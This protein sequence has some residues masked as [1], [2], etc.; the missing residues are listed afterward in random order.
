MS[1]DEWNAELNSRLNSQGHT[2]K[3]SDLQV[4]WEGYYLDGFTPQQAIDAAF[5]DDLNEYI[6]E[7]YD[8][9]S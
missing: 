5:E 8:A 3:A 2:D 4:D 6:G 9:W 1:R 7:I